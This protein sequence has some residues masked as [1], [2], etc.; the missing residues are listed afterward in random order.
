MGLILCPGTSTCHENGPP[1][2]KEKKINQG[3]RELAKKIESLEPNVAEFRKVDEK[4]LL[5]LASVFHGD[6]QNLNQVVR[7]GRN[8]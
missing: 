8:K 5:N 4:W 2:P 6:P 3:G 7:V 1:S